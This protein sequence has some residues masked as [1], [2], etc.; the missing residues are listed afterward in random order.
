[1]KSDMKCCP[2]EKV[3]AANEQLV[4]PAAMTASASEKAQ[5]KYNGWIN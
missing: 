5:T 4:H 2:V 3:I 1:M